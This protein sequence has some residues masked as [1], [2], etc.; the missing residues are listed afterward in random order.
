[1][2]ELTSETG[3]RYL[4]FEDISDLQDSAL[5]SAAAL[6]S[7]KGNFVISGC[8]VT[9]NVVEAGFVYLDGKVREVPRTEGV[10]FPTYIVAKNITEQGM[11]LDSA[12]DQDTAITYGVEFSSSNTS[13][14]KIT[15]EGP[16]LVAGM[17]LF[18]T[19]FTEYLGVDRIKVDESIMFDTIT[20]SKV[21]DVLNITGGIATPAATIPSIN[22]TNLVLGNDKNGTIRIPEVIANSSN[23]GLGI[24]Y[25]TISYKNGNNTVS[26][27][28]AGTG[29]SINSSLTLTGSLKLGSNTVISSDRLSYINNDILIWDQSGE[30]NTIRAVADFIVSIAGDSIPSFS[31]RNGGGERI[32]LTQNSIFCRQA[33]YSQDVE[34]K[35]GFDLAGGEA[36]MYIMGHMYKIA[37]SPSGFLYDANNPDFS[38]YSTNT[39]FARLDDVSE[40]NW[41]KTIDAQ[42]YTGKLSIGLNGLYWNGE[43][44][45]EQQ[46]IFKSNVVVR[47]QLTA[48]GLYAESINLKSGDQY[49]VG[50]AGQTI[51]TELT[52]VRF[53]VGSGAS[54]SSSKVSIVVD[55]VT[56]TFIG[57]VLVN[58]STQA[59]VTTSTITVPHLVILD[60]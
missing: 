23:D 11:Y 51:L 45:V 3:G 6:F 20:L 54:A 9:D 35:S 47:G 13:G 27:S 40:I 2:K 53:Q 19:I 29:A 46:S 24:S 37:V 58:I 32:E 12:N 5:K 43:F 28:F 31:V 1:M 22:G 38:E 34:P 16:E 7:G 33:T 39:K 18:S 59:G 10:S 25:N 42:D 15:S 48:P 44:M 4:F 56:K 26:L 36:K 8:T 41:K 52:N 14:I 17:V 49:F 55:K 50:K 21:N 30:R 57:G 60:N